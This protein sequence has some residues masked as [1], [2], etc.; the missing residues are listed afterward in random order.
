MKLAKWEDRGYYAL[1]ASTEKAQRQLH[2]LTRKAEEV[3]SQPAA[4]VLAAAAKAM[5]FGDLTDGDL[6]DIDVPKGKNKAARKKKAEQNA[7]EEAQEQQ[8]CQL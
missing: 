3:L 1:H 2:T 6:A 8:V 5:G 7:T 4:A